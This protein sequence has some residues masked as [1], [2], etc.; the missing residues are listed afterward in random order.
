MLDLVTPHAKWLVAVTQ[1]VEVDADGAVDAA[2]LVV[3]ERGHVGSPP[4]G[5][6]GDMTRKSLPETY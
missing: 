3:V 5:I 4:V 1:R 2:R 6:A